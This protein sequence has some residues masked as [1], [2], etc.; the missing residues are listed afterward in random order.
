MKMPT[1]ADVASRTIALFVDSV[2]KS[3]AAEGLDVYLALVEQLAEEGFD[4]AEIAAG[5]VRVAMEEKKIEVALEPERAEAPGPEEGMTRLF[6]SVGTKAGVTPADV[7]GAIA[8]EADVPGR[9]I[10][11]IDVYE[12]FTFVEVPTR[13]R[14]KV[15]G[16]MSRATIRGRPVHIKPA[17]VERGER[18]APAARRD[19]GPKGQ[20]PAAKGRTGGKPRA[21]R[22]PYKPKPGGR[23]P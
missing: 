20:K 16:A 8:N 5:A 10:G 22:K 18:G 3:V 6:L 14:D 17:D 11:V 9:E 2:R 4:M 12:R 23:Q 21:A 13:Y 15:L 19:A 1:Q 7:V